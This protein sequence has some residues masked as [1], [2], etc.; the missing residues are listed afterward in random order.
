[1]SEAIKHVGT[2][3]NSTIS[4]EDKLDEFHA[5]QYALFITA[6]VEVLGGIFFL[7]S[8][9]YIIRDKE[10]VERATNSKYF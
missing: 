1:M 10:E 4:R 9:I 2:S 7:L 3:S 6:F 5:L 8:A